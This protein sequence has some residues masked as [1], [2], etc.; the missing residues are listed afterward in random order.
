[1]QEDRDKFKKRKPKSKTSNSILNN[2]MLTSKRRTKRVERL[3]HEYDIDIDSVKKIM[4]KNKL[5]V[6]Q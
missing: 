5:N 6:Q 1:L 2:S 3:V 4:K